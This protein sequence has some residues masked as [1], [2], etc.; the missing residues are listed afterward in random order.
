MGLGT[1]SVAFLFAVWMGG[2]L[3]TP[4]SRHNIATD[5]RIHKLDATWALLQKP[6]RL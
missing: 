3:C 5:G 6:F 1:V 2:I 4:L